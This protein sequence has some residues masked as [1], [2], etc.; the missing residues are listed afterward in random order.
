MYDDRC[1][2]IDEFIYN[3]PDYVIVYAVGN[4]GED[5]SGSVGTPATAKNIIT[6]GSTYNAEERI[7]LLDSDRSQYVIPYFSAQGPTN[8]GRIKPDVVTS[9]YKIK[10]SYSNP[11]KESCDTVERSGTYIYYLFII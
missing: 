8:D 4:Y 7:S 10:S 2:Q 6:V 11:S 1:K 5:G 9:G 3:N